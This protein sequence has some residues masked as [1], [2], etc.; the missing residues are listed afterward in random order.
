MRRL[1]ILTVIRLTYQRS[2]TH[3]HH[4]LKSY[5]H[6]FRNAKCGRKIKNLKIN[7]SRIGEIIKNLRF[8]IYPLR[9]H[10]WQINKG[11]KGVS[12]M[13]LS[14]HFLFFLSCSVP[15]GWS[16]KLKTHPKDE[17][18]TLPW[19]L[20]KLFSALDILLLRILGAVL[21]LPIPN[22]GTKIYARHIQA[23]MKV[24]STCFLRGNTFLE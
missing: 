9:L 13:I 21:R 4:R 18:D 16:W 17:R 3:W 8:Y 2:Y 11:F 7:T 6:V 12:P 1:L 19:S 15:D 14:L 24:L 22:W 23:S 10:K 5:L 20:V